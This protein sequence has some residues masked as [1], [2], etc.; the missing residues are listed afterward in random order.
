MALTQDRNPMLYCISVSLFLGKHDGH[1][2][3]ARITGYVCV[4]TEMTGSQ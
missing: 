3:E 4:L 1:S 2:L